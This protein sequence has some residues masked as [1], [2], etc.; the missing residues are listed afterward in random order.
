[1][2][3]KLLQWITVIDVSWNCI[4]MQ[5]VCFED[6]LD[7]QTTEILNTS[8]LNQNVQTLSVAH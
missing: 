5:C 4:Q 6:V 7:V 1:M 3:I 8:R 2:T